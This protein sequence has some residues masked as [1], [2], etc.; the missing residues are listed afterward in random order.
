MKMN[1]TTP[2]EMPGD[3][4]GPQ[5]RK[6]GITELKHSGFPRKMRHEKHPVWRRKGRENQEKQLDGE[7]PLG[8]RR[9]QSEEGGP[10]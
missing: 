6:L 4:L 5:I 3:T 8:V 10:C 2:L 1:F 9:E 7:A